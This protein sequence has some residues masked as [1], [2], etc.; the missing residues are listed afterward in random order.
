[1]R[2]YF[3]REIERTKKTTYE[4]NKER[5][6]KEAVAAEE[7]I[8]MQ[9]MMRRLN[10]SVPS[11]YRELKNCTVRGWNREVVHMSMEGVVVPRGRIL[12]KGCCEEVVREGILL[13]WWKTITW[14][15]VG[16]EE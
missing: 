1:V 9:K 12:C 15:Q 3:Q 10:C 6:R 11:T 2:E 7:T 13:W 14:L 4:R 8:L 5:L 16:E